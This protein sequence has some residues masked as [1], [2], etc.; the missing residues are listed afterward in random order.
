MSAVAAYQDYRKPDVFYV[1]G[2]ET[3][4]DAIT[5]NGIPAL[6]SV[7]NEL[8]LVSLEVR[9]LEGAQ[10]WWIVNTSYARAGLWNGDGI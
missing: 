3:P 10:G 2:A 1:R 6:G 4:R 9:P 7:R 8:E 5:V